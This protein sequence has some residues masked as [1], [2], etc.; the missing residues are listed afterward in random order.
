MLN[1]YSEY[2]ILFRFG[3]DFVIAVIYYYQPRNTNEVFVICWDFVFV[4]KGNKSYLFIIFAFNFSLKTLLLMNFSNGSSLKWVPV[5]TTP[6]LLK[7]FLMHLKL[8]AVPYV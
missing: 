1:V 6:D 5:E 8:E 7:Y 4:E 2:L 3:E